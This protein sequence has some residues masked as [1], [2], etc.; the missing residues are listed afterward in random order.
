VTWRRSIAWI[1]G[2]GLVV[3]IGY[4]VVGQREP[5]YQ[6]RTLSEWMMKR[7]KPVTMAEMQEADEALRGIG[8]RGVPFMVEWLRCDEVPWWKAGLYAI[9]NGF[10]P[11]LVRLK[12]LGFVPEQWCMAEAASV[13]L[14]SLGP[15]ATNAVPEL[16]RIISDKNKTKEV[17]FR[18][19]CA[20]ESL[21]ED[22]L[23]CLLGALADRSHSNRVEIVHMIG[24]LRHGARPA[25]PAL[26]GCLRET[27]PSLVSEATRVLGVLKLEADVVVPEL[28]RGLS[29]RDSRVRASSAEALPSF[30]EAAKSA[31]PS[32]V[33]E[34]HDVD[35][36]ARKAAR[37]A[38]FTLAPEELE[39][40][41]KQSN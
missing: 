30:G 25:V 37:G 7:Q 31:V 35:L 8:T 21:G 12:A 1:L 18:A 41:E 23:P 11:G 27:N 20:I 5:V 40:Q 29:H 10:P 32:L 38:L 16:F 4:A 9:A 19:V 34:L 22:A 26:V 17:R 13:M 28:I 39:K 24:E 15:G 2:T 14:P 3:L 33:A 36:S 6:G